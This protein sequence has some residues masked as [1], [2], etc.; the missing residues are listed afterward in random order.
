M[1]PT[2]NP[3]S[4]SRLDAY[5]VAIELIGSLVEPAAQI[6]QRDK[7][8]VDQLRR[9]ASSVVLNI[10]EGRRRQGRDRKHLWRVAAGSAEEVRACLDVAAAWGYLQPKTVAGSLGL[11]DRLLA[12]LWRMTR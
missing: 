9:A 7:D 8:L 6:R 2:S 5:R 12:M 11:A 1:N 3:S 10:A 4:L